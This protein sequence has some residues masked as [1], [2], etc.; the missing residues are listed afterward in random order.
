MHVNL[1]HKSKTSTFHFQFGKKSL[2]YVIYRWLMGL[3]F[4]V[5]LFYGFGS[6]EINP[7]WK[8]LI[9]LTHWSFAI[10]SIATLLGAVVALHVYLRYDGNESGIYSHIYSSVPY[11]N[12]ACITRQ[13][14]IFIY[15]PKRK[16]RVSKTMAYDWVKSST[17]LP[18]L[19]SCIDFEKN[20][21]RGR[22]MDF[23]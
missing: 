8:W 9:F 6:Y 12:D 3:Y 18:G 4:T 20:P 15:S 14:K 7:W 23:M 17:V 1:W 19:G 5:S 10:L 21:E 11:K 2:V 16:S 22:P 13:G